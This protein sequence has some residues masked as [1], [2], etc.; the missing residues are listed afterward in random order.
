VAISADLLPEPEDGTDVAGATEEAEAAAVVRAATWDLD[1][2]PVTRS[3]CVTS[4]DSQIARRM[5][6]TVGSMSGLIRRA[7]KELRLLV[8]K[9][10]EGVA[11]A[12][13]PVM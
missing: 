5:R 10:G 3:G 6:R 4:K 2:D 9:F 12:L 11:C 1:P 8:A 7:R 13:L